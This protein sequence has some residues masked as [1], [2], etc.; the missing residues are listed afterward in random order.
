MGD[1]HYNNNGDWVQKS[2][3]QMANE[4]GNATGGFI[5]GAVDGAMN[6]AA[7]VMKKAAAPVGRGIGQILW[8]LIL[9]PFLLIG[10]LLKLGIVGKIIHTILFCALAFITLFSFPVL[11]SGIVK[12]LDAETADAF[13]E[14]FLAG[15]FTE[16]LPLIR[17]SFLLSVFAAGALVISLLIGIFW[18]W[19][20]HY[21]GMK[22]LDAGEYCQSVGTMFF[23]AALVFLLFNFLGGLWAVFL[24][25]WIP[26]I[27][28]F[29]MFKKLTNRPTAFVHACIQRFG[30]EE[31]GVEQDYSEALECFYYYA[32]KGYE[33][34][35]HELGVLYVNGT[36]IEQNFEYAAGWFYKA[37]IQGYAPSMFEL[38]S[39][40]YHG[41]GVP[42]DEE[43]GIRWLKKAAKKGNSL[44]KKE[45]KNI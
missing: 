27:A 19:Q 18:F 35:Q 30:D 38:A 26:L 1:Y 44:A 29:F 2:D 5:G 45:L 21:R 10:L 39:L 40:L 33:R 14:I 16:I 28:V 17:G 25:S 20:K 42:K 7:E 24:F 41:E 23:L 8:S 34:A 32:L 6:A 43:E 31:L 13:K 12:F 11:V 15:S 36:G 37:A 22:Y 4:R 9:F 3:A